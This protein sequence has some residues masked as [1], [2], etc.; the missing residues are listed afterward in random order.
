MKNLLINCFYDGMTLGQAIAYIER[1]YTETPT[2]RQIK[3]AQNSI[4]ACT[5]KEWR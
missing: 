5:G 2:D 4:K 1:C 3:L